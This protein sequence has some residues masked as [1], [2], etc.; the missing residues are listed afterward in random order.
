MSQVLTLY[1][2]PVIYLALDRI[3]R[4]I[5]AAVPPEQPSPQTSG[6]HRAM[7]GVATLT[8]LCPADFNASGVVNS[9]DYFDFLNAFFAG[10]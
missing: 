6:Q 3:N 7:R 2:T 9:Q 8:V 4:K 5:E 10:C 1:S